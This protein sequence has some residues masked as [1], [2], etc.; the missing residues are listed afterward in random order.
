MSGY[1]QR[2][3]GSVMRPRET[4]RPLVGSIFSGRKSQQSPDDFSIDAHATPL[5]ESEIP[6]LQRPPDLHG[7]PVTRLHGAKL[8]FHHLE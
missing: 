1:L 5:G 3:A 2:L 8:L 7:L 6:E 4:V